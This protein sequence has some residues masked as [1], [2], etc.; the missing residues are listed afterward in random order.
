MWVRA[1]VRGRD[2]LSAGGAQPQVAAQVS[3]LAPDQ[4]KVDFRQRDDLD[5]GFGR[6]LAQHT[7]IE[8]R[9]L[10]VQIEVANPATAQICDTPSELCGQTCDAGGGAGVEEHVS[11]HGASSGFTSAHT[12]TLESLPS[13]ALRLS[14]AA[15]CVAASGVSAAVAHRAAVPTVEAATN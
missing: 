10:R 8:Q 5:A 6:R 11:L 2:D 9:L 14:L 12:G 15:A 4:R 13:I 7:Q 1:R 3:L